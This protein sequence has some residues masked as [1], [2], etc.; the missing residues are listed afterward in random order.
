MRSENDLAESSPATSPARRL[1]DAFDALI[2]VPFAERSAW[3]ESN[4]AD[5]AQRTELAKLVEADDARGYL[6]TPVMER[7][8]KLAADDLVTATLVGTKIG[9]FRLVAEIGRGGM[10]A[11]FL[12]ERE[13]SDVTQRVAVKLLR[14][15]LY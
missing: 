9:A 5:A 10:A 7:A 14:R 2:E 12:A 8:A 15:G 6:D 4:I 13:G 3:L 1:R 11:V